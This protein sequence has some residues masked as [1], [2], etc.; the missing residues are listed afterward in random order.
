MPE[1]SGSFPSDEVIRNTGEQK[2]K[3]GEKAA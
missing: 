3:K 1:Q 2:G